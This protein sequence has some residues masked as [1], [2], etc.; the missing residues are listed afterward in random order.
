[1]WLARFA[2]ILQQIAE[3]SSPFKIK[4]FGGLLH[5]CFD[6]VHHLPR[7]PIKHFAGLGNSP[8]VIVSG[9]PTHAGGRAV[10]DY[11]IEAVFEIQ[12]RR[13]ERTTGAEAE[14]LPDGLK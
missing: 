11:M 1:M 2:K 5:L 12:L 13:L 4:L 7:F 6:Q 8:V 9:N 10:L 3:G 14:L